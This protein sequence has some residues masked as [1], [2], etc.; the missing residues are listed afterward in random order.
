MSV[1]GTGPG[2]GNLIAGNGEC[3]VEIYEIRAPGTTYG[4]AILG[5]S[6]VSNVGM[7]IDHGG[8]GVTSNDSGDP[9]PGPNLLQNFPV[10]TLADATPAGITIDGTLN[11]GATREFRLEFFTSTE[12]DASGCGEGERYLGFEDVTTDFERQRGLQRA[13][14]GTRLGRGFDHGD[15]HGRRSTTPRSSPTA[16]SRRASRSRRFGQTIGAADKNTLVW[17][18]CERRPLRRRANSPWSTPT[19]SAT[20]ERCSAPRRSTF[21]RISPDTGEPAVLP[22]TTARLRQLA[23]RPGLGGGKRPGTSVAPL[24]L[25]T[26]AV[27]SPEREAATFAERYGA[28]AEEGAEAEV[29]PL[30]DEQLDTL[31]RSLERGVIL[32]VDYGER[33]DRLYGPAHPDGTLLAYRR[34]TTNCDYLEHVGE[35]DLTAWVNFTALEDRA[36]ATGLDVLGWTTQDRFL[37]A[38]G[39]SRPSSR[40]MR[41][42]AT[43]RA[44]SR[45]ACRR[46]S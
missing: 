40:T 33:A 11:S 27:N 46:C 30:V 25:Y 7:G 10:V 29:A 18:G 34:H 8:D 42:S 9:D 36:R 6:I 17:A 12:C 2:A 32:I 19:P 35:Q 41:P 13:P 20:T 5:N 15:G 23:K 1:G 16:S 14:R 21:R 38:N 26:G 43:T 22:R 24:G 31:Q 37:I 28:A 39:S 45:R 44:G 3:G 4:N